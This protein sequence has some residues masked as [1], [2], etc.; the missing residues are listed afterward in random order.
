MPGAPDGG[1]TVVK[2]DTQFENKKKAVEAVV[3]EKSEHWEACDYSIKLEPIQK[4]KKDLKCI[5][6]ITSQPHKNSNYRLRSIIISEKNRIT[7]DNN[8]GFLVDS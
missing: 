6:S 3:F 4:S 2:F 5:G 7:W 1:Y 8:R